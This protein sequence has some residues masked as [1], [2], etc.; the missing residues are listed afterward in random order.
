MEGM[1]DEYSAC[2]PFISS[3]YKLKGGG[4]ENKRKIFHENKTIKPKNA[5]QKTPL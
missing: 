2:S 3:F 4:G 5:P 1:A